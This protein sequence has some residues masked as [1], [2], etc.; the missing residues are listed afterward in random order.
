MAVDPRKRQKKLQRKAA[1][2]KAKKKNLAFRQRN[3]LVLRMQGAA[4]AP[5]LHCVRGA[6]M[7]EDGMGTLIVSRKLSDGQVA[8]GIFM[9]DTFCLGVKSAYAEIVPLSLYEEKVYDATKQREGLV[10]LSLPDAYKLVEDSAAYA[11]QFG[12]EPNKD[13]A[14]AKLIF[15]DV[16][17]SLATQ[18]FTFGRGGKP[19]YVSGPYDGIGR[20]QWILDQ[21]TAHC[22]T[23]GFYTV[24]RMDAAHGEWDHE[25]MYLED[26]DAEEGDFDDE[27]EENADTIEGTFERQQ[28]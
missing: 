17:V 4:K 11:K 22:G 15:G 12:F 10:A 2:D 19:L 25:G 5:L 3:E 20:S 9:L 18:E 16:D 28:E 26:D 24:M 27:F 1:K 6:R 14:K 13:Y 21:L 23:D 7:F 8:F